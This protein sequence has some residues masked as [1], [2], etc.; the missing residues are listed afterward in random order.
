MK[1]VQLKRTA[2]LRY[3]KVQHKTTQKKYDATRCITKRSNIKRVQH[4]KSATRKRY[5]TKSVQH[6]KSVTGKSATRNEYDT[7][8]VQQ[9]MGATRSTTKNCAS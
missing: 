6:V 7:K 4:E 2:T 3:S 9:E 5:S 8:K 1:I